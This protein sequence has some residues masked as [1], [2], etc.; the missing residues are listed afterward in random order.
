M[1]EFRLTTHNAKDPWQQQLLAAMQIFGDKTPLWVIP[2]PVDGMA[3]RIY[4][5]DPE[6]HNELGE[7]NVSILAE[8]ARLLETL[9][10]DTEEELKFSFEPDGRVQHRTWFIT[11]TNE[12]GGT[13]I[14]HVSPGH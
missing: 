13:I 10:R 4:T 3:V 6:T 1:P 5:Y 11:R 7:F 12:L 8:F 14:F 9:T 2:P